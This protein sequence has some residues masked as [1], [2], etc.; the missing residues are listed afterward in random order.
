MQT[1]NNDRWFALDKGQHLIG[2]MILTI[3][4]ASSL[5]KY[6]KYSDQKSDIV[7]ASFSFFIGFGKEMCD[8]NKE[9]NYFSFKDLT[10]NITGIVLGLVLLRI[11]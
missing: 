7:G 4:T 3:G 5:K 11:D 1:G 10:A 6:S 2:S 8:N 9:N